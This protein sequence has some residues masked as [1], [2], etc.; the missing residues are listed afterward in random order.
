[1]NNKKF[2][3]TDM[4]LR[5]A[6]TWLTAVFLSMLLLTGCGKKAVEE[7]QVQVPE[8]SEEEKAQYVSADGY[9]DPAA[10]GAAGD[11]VTDDTEALQMAIESGYN[12]RLQDCT[13]FISG[14]SYLKVSDKSDFHMEGGIIHREADDSNSSL[15]VLKNCSDCSFS[16]MQIYSEFSCKDILVPKNHKRPSETKSSNVLAFSGTGNSNILF[17][18]NS[19]ACMG[20][21]YWFN[22]TEDAPWQNIT[23]DGW[24][25]SSTLMP[26]Y[27]QCV[28]G[29]TVK[30]ADVAL[31]PGCG[32]GDHCMYVC[33]K[34]SD[35][36]IEDSTFTGNDTEELM[37]A[38][39]VLTFH[40]GDEKKD[41]QPKNI[42]INNCSINALTG[43]AI[44]CEEGTDIR[45]TDSSV[46]QQTAAEQAATGQEATGQEAAEQAAT[47]QMATGQTAA[48][49][50]AT[51]QAAAEQTSTGQTA[52]EQTAT[53][54]KA[55]EQPATGQE[56]AEKTDT[57]QTQG[58][59]DESSASGEGS[60]GNVNTPIFGYGSYTFN[61]CEIQ[62]VDTVFEGLDSLCLT[63]CSV[64]GAGT[65]AL[66][67]GVANVE[68]DGCEFLI[69]GGAAVYMNESSHP[70]H[71]YENCSFVKNG[72]ALAYLFSD[73]SADG[74]ITL[75]D[76]RVDVGNQWF[77]YDGAKKS[78]SG[79][80]LEN[81]EISNSLGMVMG[82]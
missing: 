57:E 51:E 55:A 24:T 79:Y 48:E 42:E 1:M 28:T 22:A 52:V 59:N 26:M 8:L 17:Q 65:N 10:Y 43:R 3:R 27:T 78:T 77:S 14:E 6:I 36:L 34:T 70:Q 49:Q 50:K 13:Y 69:N 74:Q 54:Q 44:Y 60:E 15:F 40:G 80:I 67:T 25:S 68:A 37:G 63:D 45:V 64:Q 66:I 71:V 21:D 56:V 33:Y 31:N 32:D 47:G 62:A 2:L 76:C 39:V 30:N 18:D 5:T 12:V 9:V 29:L 4:P 73:R 16:N 46:I 61:R 19:F 20:S 72:D 7:I 81:T 75:K 58:E 41:T 35:V 23:V 82:E 11:G 38:V 53:G